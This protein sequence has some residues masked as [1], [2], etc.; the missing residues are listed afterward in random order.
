MVTACPHCRIHF[1]CYLDGKPVDPL[2]PLK[3]VDL[4]VLA[5]QALG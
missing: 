2:P 1:S 3:I 5:A 4:T